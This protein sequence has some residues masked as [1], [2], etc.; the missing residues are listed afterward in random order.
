MG[1]WPG[2]FG[3]VPG[4]IACMNFGLSCEIREGATASSSRK[5][6]TASTG[7]I[8]EN[9]CEANMEMRINN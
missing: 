1:A 7:K 8:E 9:E 3:R 4:W 5:Y 2:V 6:S